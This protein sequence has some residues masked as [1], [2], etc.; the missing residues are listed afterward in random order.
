MTAVLPVD[1][2]PAIKDLRREASGLAQMFDIAKMPELFIRLKDWRRNEINQT[3][4][5]VEQEDPLQRTERNI[6][7][8]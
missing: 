2:I 5:E 7:R 8:T 6:E 1:G 4:A 3:K